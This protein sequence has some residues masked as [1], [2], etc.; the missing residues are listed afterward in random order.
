[1]TDE[2][3]TYKEKWWFKIITA[4]PFVNFLK[5]LI[6]KDNPASAHSFINIVWGFGSFILYWIDHFLYHKGVFTTNDLTFIG[7]LAG[8]TTLSAVA[9]KLVDNKQGA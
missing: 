4:R 3:G 5:D 7:G 1:M 9:S 6:N 2:T 8:I